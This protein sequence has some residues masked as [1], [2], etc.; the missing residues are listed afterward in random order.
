QGDDFSPPHEEPLIRARRCFPPARYPVV[1]ATLLDH[2]SSIAF[3]RAKTA[4][5]RAVT[6]E[7]RASLLQED[8][9][10]IILLRVESTGRQGSVLGIS[11]RAGE[12][13][14]HR[15]ERKCCHRKP[16][17]FRKHAN[18]TTPIAY[19]SHATR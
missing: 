2:S 9:A 5:G 11:W 14:Q 12:N 1:R 17:R 19:A 13:K 15:N 16:R 18:A 7:A 6:V 4:R 3:A 8:N 10:G